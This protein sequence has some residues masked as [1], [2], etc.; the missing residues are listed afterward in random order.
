[1]I[2]LL[3]F[4]AMIIIVVGVHEWG[5]YL[6]ARFFGVRVLRFSIGFGKPLIKKTD[7]AG[8]EWALAPIPL[9]GYV[10]ML[11]R[12]SLSSFP[13]ATAQQT[14][15]AQNNWARFIIYAAG[16]LANIVLS[17]FI[18]I[19]VFMA[20]ETG[21]LARIGKVVENS[22]A[23]QAGLVAGDDIIAV[24]G[25]KTLLWQQAAMAL[26][27][28]ALQEEAV[29]IDTTVGAYTLP[30]G[31]LRPADVENGLLSAAGLIPDMSYLTQ[32]IQAVMPESAAAKAGLKV[33]D[34]V[35]AIDGQVLDGWS[36]LVT[37]VQARPGQEAP[38]IL[39]RDGGVLT[40]VVRFDE[41]RQG[42]RAIGQLGVVPAVAAASLQELL[43][44]VQL[45]PGAAVVSAWQRVGSDIARTFAFLG[46][47]VAG[48]LS[49]EKNISG[50]VG[51]AVGAGAAAN[52]GT[53]WA[54]VALI[55]I[56]LA[57][58]NLLPLPL[59]DG[60]QMVICVIQSLIRRPLPDKIL[61]VLERAGMVLLL[62][63]MAWIILLDLTRL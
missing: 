60:G 26:V 2:T 19:G 12:N 14:M 31:S 13:G 36:D 37:L 63:L 59:L 57:V 29:Y 48:K 27:D 4:I 6:A 11:D 16:P 17:F 1:M 9:G 44:T 30:A 38:I 55:S 28:A 51:I 52:S 24:N 32:T 47:M 18:L 61:Q 35:V 43:T 23:A 21:L 33:G 15:E 5:H 34:L 7:K 39:W 25:E 56:S 58:I 3:Y 54:F 22:P 50:P 40:A 53:W 10:R 49:F 41:V 8:T 20:G 46:G 42:G 45:S 62:F